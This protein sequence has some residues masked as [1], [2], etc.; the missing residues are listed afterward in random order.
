MQILFVHPNF[1]AQFG[2]VGERFSK[3]ED[4]QCV[5]VSRNASG[6][7][8][9]FDC[10]PYQLRGGATKGNHYCSR[11][12]ENAVWNSHAVY[13]T[14]KA[15]PELSPDLIV[16]HS[17]FG[18]TA[19]L[20]E[21]YDAPIVNLFEYFYRSRGTDM[22]FRP[23]YP[24]SELDRL[25]A[26]MRNAMILVD[27]MTCE[28]GYAPTHF[29][30]D[31]FPESVRGL[32]EVAHDGIET[33][34]WYPRE[35]DRSVN[36]ET[37]GPET[38]LVTYVSRGFESMRGFDQFI[39]AAKAILDQRD[40]VVFLVVGEEG[41]HYG[42]D[43]KHVGQLS[44]KEHIFKETGAD[45]SSFR[46]LGRLSRDEL[47]RVL[48]MSEAH[49]YLTV[50]FVLSWSML[51]AMACGAPIVGSSTPPVAEVI[52]D[53]ENGVLVDFH[54]PADIAE[55]VLRVLDDAGLAKR[56]SENGLTT[57]HER[58]SMEVCFPRLEG[59]YA[60]ALG[61]EDLSSAGHVLPSTPQAAPQR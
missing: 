59:L 22:D 8:R 12:F 31:L 14:C 53:A 15:T 52:A 16:G 41:T 24:S 57:I 55:G 47:A 25:R 40:D 43:K 51:N 61:R 18:S 42:N 6:H 32:L 36:G 3:R 50:P 34:I 19:M 39:R 4:T 48:S 5:F 44:F 38:R 33:D 7:Q 10:V 11:T 20:A 26:R 60:S 27:S 13:E 35:H 2:P 58:Y 28:V 9:G 29:Q 17:G 30:R 45:E 21:L 46:F 49:I 56:L 1:P 23:E 54:E 37:F